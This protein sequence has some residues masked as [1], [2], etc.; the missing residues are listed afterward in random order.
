MT[1]V[2]PSTGAP[3]TSY[4]VEAGS[5]PGLANLA[6]LD[7]GTAVTALAVPNVPVGSYWI[8]V[9]GRSAAGLGPASQE[10]SLSMSAGSGC[11]GLP[12]APVLLTPVVTGNDVSLNWIA[13]P[14]GAPASYVILAGSAPG[15]SN[16]ASF[17][18]GSSATTFAGSAPNGLYHVRVAAG[19]ACGRGPVSN[20]MVFTLGPERP[21]APQQLQASVGAGGAVTLT[22]EAP[23][24]GG[25]PTAYLVEAGNASGLANLAM[26][27]T[28]ST[29]TVFV[30]SAQPGTYFVRVRAVNTAGPGDA[31]N[32]VVVVVP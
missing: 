15:T 24:T 4:V 13:P 30:A 27:S 12:G 6:T 9:R 1:W 7:T 17:S 28:G 16:L 21:G 5:G 2:A 3:A 29:A 19:S 32:E 22:W 23:A 8:R 20:E 25:S 14:G 11:V 18:T 10:V 26:V 31:S